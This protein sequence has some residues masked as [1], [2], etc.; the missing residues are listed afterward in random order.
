MTFKK[1]FFKNLFYNKKFVIAFSVIVAFLFWLI[2]TLVENPE[3]EITFSNINI[4]MSMNDQASESGLEIISSSNTTANVTVSGPSYVL[5]TLSVN[6]IAVIAQLDDITEAGEQQI[7]LTANCTKVGDIK[8]VGVSPAKVTAVFDYRDTKDFVVEVI[9][10]GVTSSDKRLTRGTPVVSNAV[11]SSVEITGPRKELEKIAKVVAITDASEAISVTKSYDARIVLYDADGNKIDTK[12]FVLS[13][14]T[15]KITVPI[16][17]EK[18]LPVKAAFK[19]TPDAYLKTPI[20]HTVSINEIT[21]LGPE[22]TVSE[23]EF[24]ALSAID[25]DTISAGNKT[26]TVT[27]DLPNGVKC[28]DNVENVSVEITATSI[29]D[30]TLNVNEIKFINLGEGLKASAGTIKNVKISGPRNMVRN[31]KS[32]ELFATADLAGKAAGKHTVVVRIGAENG[33]NI[34]QVGTYEVLVTIE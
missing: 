29:T 28:V 16:L 9:A 21:V 11:D 4:S 6:D 31:I 30:R 24:I 1:D 27:L 26:F 23:M 19:N 7:S 15:I 5:A 8:I 18:T 14:D 3:R 34:W 12:N 20:S 13:S 32:S 2:V 10:D 17:L 25:F 22:S 33:K